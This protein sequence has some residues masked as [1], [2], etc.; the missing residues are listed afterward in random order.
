MFLCVLL[1]F[2]VYGQ[3]KTTEDTI[4]VFQNQQFS[5]TLDGDDFE[6]LVRDSTDINTYYGE[7]ERVGNSLYLIKRADYISVTHSYDLNR[8]LDFLGNNVGVGITFSWYPWTS[9]ERIIYYDSLYYFI[10]NTAVKIGSDL[11]NHEIIIE[12]PDVE[13]FGI[14]VYSPFGKVFDEMVKLPQN[15][16]YIDFQVVLKLNI[17]E[18][19]VDFMSL[20]EKPVNIDGQDFW[21]VWKDW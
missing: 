10:N 2:G 1:Q 4:Q 17:E 16:N 13:T 15:M 8:N 11:E 14:S 21:V 6:L 3:I 20:F 12:R 19:S 7:Y 9:E 5:L 18:F